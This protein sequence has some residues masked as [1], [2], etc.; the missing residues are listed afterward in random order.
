MDCMGALGGTVALA[1]SGRV[2]EFLQQSKPPHFHTL[3]T[4]REHPL[5]SSECVEG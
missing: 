2:H 1:L 3:G 4:Q 5:V